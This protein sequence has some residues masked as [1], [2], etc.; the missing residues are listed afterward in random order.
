MVNNYLKE[1]TASLGRYATIM[2]GIVLVALMTINPG[3]LRAATLQAT[4][5]ISIRYNYIDNLYANDP[6]EL[7]SG[8]GLVSAQYI[9]YL[10]GLTLAYRV[11]RHVLSVNGSAGYEQFVNVTGW[12]EDRNNTSPMDYSALRL[13]ATVRYAY[14]YPKF[15]FDISDTARQNRDL[16]QVFGQGTDVLGYWPL[17][18]D[19]VAAVAVRTQLTPKLKTLFQYSYE[20]LVFATPQG[21]VAPPPDSFENRGY[22]RSEYS[23]TPRTRGILDLQGA[24]RN[25]G[26][27]NGAKSAD[28]VLLQ[29]MVGISHFFS[30]RTNLTVLGGYAQRNF[31]DLSNQRLSVV[32]P[33]PAFA[34]TR[35][36][37]LKNMGDPVGRATLSFT[38]PANNSLNFIAEQGISTYGQNL[39]FNYTLFAAVAV[40]H[41]TPNIRGNLNLQYRQTFY[42][43]E[44]NGR[45]WEWR[46]DRKDNIM[47]VNGLVHWDVL[48]KRN[49][50]TLMLEAG[51]IYQNRDSSIDN[52]ADY[53]TAYVNFYG[54]P[55]DSNDAIVTTY[56]FNVQIM[57]TLLFG[58]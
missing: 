23:F 38:S 6:N 48:K 22:F 35:A 2:T 34:G 14:L 5:D 55:V 40:Y 53:T 21:D 28:Y 49:Q 20:S 42:D 25:F 9:D 12:V 44:K 18:L 11:G 7:P 17:F 54:T 19:N 33:D 46:D 15:T 8:G 43:R 56:Y 3:T 39:F 51:A 30:P 24:A 57:P 36:F 10:V 41:F 45:E 26:E 31:S 47:Y 13:E 37:D 29:G 52:K 50:G 27:V 1:Q 32:W 58:R 16:Q 4:P